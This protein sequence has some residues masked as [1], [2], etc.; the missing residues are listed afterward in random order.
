MANVLVPIADGSE[1]I[2]AVTII[3]V[4]V[5][6]GAEVTVASVMEHSQIIAS[7]GVKLDANCLIG[8]CGRE[9]DLIALPG[10]LPGADHLAQ[11][12]PLMELVRQQL[13]QQRLLA[14]ICAAPAVV[15]GRHGLLADRVA[16]CYPGFQEELAS[17][18]RA[19][20]VER[21]VEDENLITS[22]GPGTA[23]EFSLAL[24]TRLFG[25]EKAAAVADGLLSR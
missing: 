25:S 7:R 21:V 11:S 12:G 20:S 4:L 15:L 18:A 23:M 6:A 19:V 14:A 8:S 16:T 3:D 13:A 22:Q 17:Q 24:V 2:E 9:W 10:G 5:R 1:E